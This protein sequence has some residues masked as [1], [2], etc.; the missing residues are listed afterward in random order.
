VDNNEL[1]ALQADKQT[2]STRCFYLTLIFVETDDHTVAVAMPLHPVVVIIILAD[3][4]IS[5]HKKQHWLCIATR[6][7]AI[8][9]TMVRKQ[10]N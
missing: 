6:S 1:H 10:P 8:V 9:I 4:V 5:L 2:P 7:L 3:I